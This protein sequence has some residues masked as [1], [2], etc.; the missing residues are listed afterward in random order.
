MEAR[1]PS[2]AITLVA[3]FCRRHASLPLVRLQHILFD[4]PFKGLALVVAFREDILVR[5]GAAFKAVGDIG[6]IG[7]RGI[8]VPGG[9]DG[10]DVRAGRANWMY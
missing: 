8:A 5:A 6:C 3:L 7:L 10:E 4:F 1:L 9:R 2:L